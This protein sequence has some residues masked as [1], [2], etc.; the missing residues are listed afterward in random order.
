MNWKGQSI[1]NLLSHA[2]NGNL[3]REFGKLEKGG[4]MGEISN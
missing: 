3:G 1:E 2:V 4:S